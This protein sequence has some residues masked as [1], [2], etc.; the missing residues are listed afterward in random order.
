MQGNAT[1][2]WQLDTTCIGMLDDTTLWI[3]CPG[4]ASIEGI[5]YFDALK[6]LSLSGT[7]I[8]G[9]APLPPKLTTLQLDNTNITGTLPLLPD[10]LRELYIGYSA[11]ITALPP[12]LPPL[13]YRLDVPYCAIT[14]LP[15]LPDSLRR[16]DCSGNHITSLP[17]L[18]ALLTS[19]YCN[20]NNLT[21]LP[22]LP[23]GL[24]NISCNN[25]PLTVLPALPSTL[26][27]LDCSYCNLTSLP[28]L[29]PVLG[30]LY[31]QANQLSTL[32]PLPALLTYLFCGDTLLTSLPAMSDSLRYFSI[33]NSPALTSLPDFNEALWEFSC[34]NTGIDTLPQLPATIYTVT[35]NQNP[36]TTISGSFPIQLGNFTCT[37]S[38]ISSLPELPNSLHTLH[39]DF[40]PTLLCV[41]W[42][43]QD[44]YTFSHSNSGI[45]CV[46]NRPPHWIADLPLCDSV[47]PNG[48][49]LYYYR[50][51]G[52]AWLDN[53]SNCQA[54]GPESTLQNIPVKIY[55]HGDWV[56]LCT[57]S[58]YGNYDYF[59]VKDT[60]NIYPDTTNIPFTL[61]CP[62]SGYYTVAIKDSGAAQKN[63]GYH[64]KG[65]DLIAQS[66]AGPRFRPGG[67]TTLHLAVGQAGGFYNANCAQGV[68]GTITLT[69]DPILTYTGV[70]GALSPSANAGNT[71]VWQVP[72]FGNLNFLSGLN[73][74]FA[75]CAN[76]P[77]GTQ[78]CFTVTVS[79]TAAETDTTNNRIIWCT[80]VTGSFDPN[81]KMVSPETDID[82]GTHWL[83]YTINFQNTGNDTAFDIYITDTLDSEVDPASFRLL[84][85]SHPVSTEIKGNAMRF[86]F[87][88]IL[89][90]DSNTNEPLS[91]GFVQYKIRIRDNMPVGTEITNTADIYFDYNAPVATNTTSTT[92]T[93]VTSVA[94][95]KQ[96]GDNVG[97]SL[98]PNPA[99]NN[100]TIS[101]RNNQPGTTIT[102]T[103][104]TGRKM[105][106]SEMA[107]AQK[108]LSTA[109]L[110]VGIY[111]VTAATREGLSETKR[112]VISK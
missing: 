3:H 31:C 108:Q 11:N 72:D 73:S 14:V 15:A 19:L 93:N 25:N 95:I 56:Q 9:L 51:T 84:N 88:N 1:T 91:H 4:C 62:D 13:L 8:T 87:A 61:S 111:F 38:H 94:V 52:K 101:L 26:N 70:A 42:L 104:I 69:Y 43:P 34:N 29:S 59:T 2:G 6:H 48:G 53:N 23:T 32:P 10:S 97:L 98:Y 75:T 107:A 47:N 112:L 67:S 68:G 90:P 81:E 82:T 50:V 79:T 57:T 5:A 28:A 65:L 21:T 12:V 30:N 77:I 80:T 76:V 99:N 35:C 78:L 60:V 102:L 20:V 17:A 58:S 39:V 96:A 86:N 46:P 54:D 41:P 83:T 27:Y 16:L 106:T 74:V 64:C 63:F 66:A 100:V 71:L 109:N 7:P 89:L 105:Y 103:D 36:I 33:E 44:L 45:G 92:I 37:N 110:A 85:Y 18:P 24:R 55:K 49:C 40:N 22:P